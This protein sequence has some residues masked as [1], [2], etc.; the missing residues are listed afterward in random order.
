M[1]AS[2][3][4]LPATRRT[5]LEGNLARVRER[6]A[7]ALARAGRAPKDARL[8]GVTKSVGAAVAR[9][10]FELGLTDLGENRVQE[11]ERKAQA[12]PLEVE[13]HLIG[14]VQRNKA[15]RAVKFASLL[16]AIDRDVIV[17]RL[18]AAAAELHRRVRGFLEVHLSDEPSKHG[19]P[20][21]DVLRFLESARHHPNVELVGL[22]TMAPLGATAPEIRSIFRALRQLRD[23][24]ARAGLFAGSGPGALSMG[25]S[26]DFEIA[27]E[28]GSTHVRIGSALFEGIDP[29]DGEAP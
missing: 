11:L 26:Q 8:I 10:L 24:A 28:E 17:P 1:N 16:H 7:R 25:M 15:R 29:N 3:T 12:L 2:D 23:D 19:V 6:L 20:R 9:G 18:D 27:A 14:P 5:I 13:W 21:N 4:T 22:M